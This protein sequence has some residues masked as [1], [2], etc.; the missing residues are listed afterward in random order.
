M[1]WV[2][3]AGY[4]SVLLRNRTEI[5]MAWTESTRKQYERDKHRYSSDVSDGVVA[6]MRPV[7]LGAP[8]LDRLDAP[9]AA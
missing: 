7:L 3:S 8:F 2:N 5:E 1:S 9:D 6:R 4:D